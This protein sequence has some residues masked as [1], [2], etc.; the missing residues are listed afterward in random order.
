MAKAFGFYI[1]DSKAQ[2]VPVREDVPPTHV[3]EMRVE[4]GYSDLVHGV[5]HHRLLAQHF[6]KSLPRVAE[7]ASSNWAKFAPLFLDHFKTLRDPGLSDDARSVLAT[8]IE[9]EA[10]RVLKERESPDEDEYEGLDEPGDLWLPG[11][12]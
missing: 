9:T 10:R 2:F 12:E 5:R 3:E 1:A 11:Y 4:L 6:G 7:G 8:E